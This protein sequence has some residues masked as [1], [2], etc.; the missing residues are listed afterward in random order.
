M[1][2]GKKKKRG[3]FCKGCESYKPN[4]R[5]SGKGHAIHLCKICQSNGVYKK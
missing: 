1:G 2:K 5:F 4:E 3:H